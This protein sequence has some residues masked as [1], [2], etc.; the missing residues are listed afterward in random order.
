MWYLWIVAIAAVVLLWALNEH[1]SG[2]LKDIGSGVLIWAALG[3][4]IGAFIVSG[5]K[6]G[7]ATLG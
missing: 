6:V 7:L 5:W 4:V 1:L 3:L 2:S